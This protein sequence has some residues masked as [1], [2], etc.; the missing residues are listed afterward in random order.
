MFHFSRK[1]EELRDMYVKE[2]IQH[3]WNFRAKKFPDDWTALKF[4]ALEETNN[5]YGGSIAL[6]VVGGGY[7]HI[8]H[9]D[10]PPHIERDCALG[11]KELVTELENLL[12]KYIEDNC[13]WD[14]LNES[15][16]SETWLK[17]MDMSQKVSDVTDLCR[18]HHI[19]SLLNNP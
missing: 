17:S 10:V 13:Y 4:I 19:P 15:T 6:P 2:T 12:N 16:Q 7:V 14:T 9:L 11:P 8:T 18:L 1:A 5:V 3:W